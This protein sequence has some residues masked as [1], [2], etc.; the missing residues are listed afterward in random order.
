M[1]REVEAQILYPREKSLEAR[2][3]AVTLRNIGYKVVMKENGGRQILV[4]VNGNT[5]EE[6][7]L[8]GWL[9]ILRRE[10]IQH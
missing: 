7:D 10:Y 6:D 8:Y 1:R 5:V 4:V 3:L 2:V 9:R